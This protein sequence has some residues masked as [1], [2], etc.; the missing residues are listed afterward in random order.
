MGYGMGPRG[1][2]PPHMPP[3]NYMQGGGP[4]GMP[5]TFN[6]PPPRFMPPY[7]QSDAGGAVI[8]AGPQLNNPALVAPQLTTPPTGNSPALM[9]GQSPL[10]MGD[11]HMHAPDGMNKHDDK[12]SDEKSEKRVWTEHKSPDGRIY[13][14]N[15][16]TRASVWDKPDELKSSSELLLSQCPWKE[17]KSESGKIYFHNVNTKESRWTIPKEL[18]DLKNKIAQENDDKANEKKAPSAIELAMAATLAAIEVPVPDNTKAS[19][20]NGASNLP[21][22]QSFKPLNLDVEILETKPAP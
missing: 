6:I 21:E 8:S 15:T 19:T 10:P 3:P 22:E 14:Y 9:D 17:Y 16:V 7:G 11:L 5:P 12:P 1:N 20:S 4:P 18:E 13:Y 2:M